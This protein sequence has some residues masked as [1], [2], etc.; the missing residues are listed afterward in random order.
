[1]AGDAGRLVAQRQECRDWAF[2][3]EPA[4]EELGGEQSLVQKAQAAAI[5]R[6]GVQGVEACTT[7]QAPALQTGTACEDC[8][9]EAGM[10]TILAAI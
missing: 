3:A 4:S 7:G 5:R 1:M 9:A 6:A 10:S 2:T 8:D